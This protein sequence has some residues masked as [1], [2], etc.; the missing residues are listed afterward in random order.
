MG[1][2]RETPVCILLALSYS[3]TSVSNCSG[4]GS[5][6]GPDVCLC[7]TGYSGISCS[8]RCGN[9]I[10]ETPA[11][12]CD[13]GNNVSGDGCSSLCS[14]GTGDILFSRQERLPSPADERCYCAAELLAGWRCQRRD[15]MSNVT[16]T[17]VTV[18]GAAVTVCLTRAEAASTSSLVFADRGRACSASLCFMCGNGVV[19]GDEQCDSAAS[20]GSTPGCAYGQRSC[21]VRLSSVQLVL[22][23]TC[24][25]LHF[26]GLAN[27]L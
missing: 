12:D 4:H 19:E 17:N 24:S 7:D 6:I 3:C 26:Q 8:Q 18:D 27:A 1:L 21:R 25:T 20:S 23:R 16:V 5:C 9:G 15:E 22:L 13:D 2:L 10:V 11:E 14:T